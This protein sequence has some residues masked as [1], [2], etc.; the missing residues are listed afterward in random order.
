MGGS[1]LGSEAIY[2]FLNHKIKKKFQFINNLNNFL[3]TTKDINTKK[4][5]VVI[6]KSGNTLE[7]I[8]NLNLILK[9]KKNNYIFITEKNENYLRRIAEKLKCVKGKYENVREN[10]AQSIFQI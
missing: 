2:Q 4:L 5:N 3:Q 7:T 10:G 1:I 6:S 9:E 8:S